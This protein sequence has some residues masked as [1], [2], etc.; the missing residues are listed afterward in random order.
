MDTVRDHH[1]LGI[2]N[3]FFLNKIHKVKKRHNLFCFEIRLKTWTKFLSSIWTG[4]CFAPSR[5]INSLKNCLQQSVSDLIASALQTG[6]SGPFPR[7]WMFMCMFTL[8][9]IP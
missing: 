2:I 5:P 8:D 9:Y 1:A 7:T 3:I 4:S 6:A